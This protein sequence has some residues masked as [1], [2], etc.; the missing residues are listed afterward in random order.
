MQLPIPINHHAV[1]IESHLEPLPAVAAHQPEDT[2]NQ[3]PSA[4]AESDRERFADFPSCPRSVSWKTPNR[5]DY[6]AQEKELRDRAILLEK[7]FADYGLN[8][9]VVGI[10]T[11]PVITQY[12][13]ALETGLR[14]NKV[15][16]LADDL[17]LNLRVPHVRMVAP[18]PGKSSVGIE[19]PNEMRAV[20]CLKEVMAASAKKVAKSKLPLYLGKDAEGRPLVYDL[21]EMPHLLIAGSTGTGK[22]VCL[23]SI[24]LSLLM[25]RR[26]DEVKMIMVDPKAVELSEYGKL[27]HLIHPVVTD[28]KKAEAILAWAVD[29]M[30]E[31]YDLLRRAR[32]RNL[33]EYNQ[34]KPDEIM[35]RIAPEDDEE[36]E[37]VPDHMPYIVIIID[38]MADLIMQMRKEVE[39]HIIRL[40]QKSRAAGIHLV[41]ATQR[42]TV[43]VITGLIK[44]NLP[45]RICFKVTNKSDSRVVLD[46]M[47]ADKMLGKGD[48]LFLPP[49]T[50]TLTRG[51]GT[52]VSGDTRWCIVPSRSWSAAN[53]A[54][55]SGTDATADRRRE[56][57]AARSPAI[58]RRRVRIGGRSRGTRRA[59]Q[60]VAVAAGARHRLRAGG[61]ADRL[62]GRGRHR[63][64]LQGQQCPRSPLHAG[65]MVGDERAPAAG[66]RGVSCC[67]R[68]RLVVSRNDKSK[69]IAI[70]T[71]YPLALPVGSP[72]PAIP[73]CRR[74]SS[75]RAACCG[76][77]G[78]A[79]GSNGS[80]P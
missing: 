60:R 62:H 12:E 28:M 55:P 7:T 14:V 64:R 43:D 11:G 6:A 16:S 2:R 66:D 19:I 63:R 5:F 72:S 77:A 18:I 23:N 29:K 70:G 54:T 76:R 35:R 36:R 74:R 37:Q 25:T 17:A 56:G 20:V 73:A 22:S 78:P 26:P 34:L 48:M 61:A 46:Q 69:L 68:L 57:R 4:A 41:L 9:N 10:N 24:I 1:A 50:S 38:E 47:G 52:F 51:Q 45:A 13:V 40:A 71:S 8:V 27:P 67:A 21:A 42:P 59:R 30:E 32:V 53:P 79:P 39:G 44:S 15:T 33:A 49:G 80:R 3:A 58:A 75:S 65:T 31:R